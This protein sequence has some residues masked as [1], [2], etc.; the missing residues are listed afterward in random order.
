[1]LTNNVKVQRHFG[2]HDYHRKSVRYVLGNV[3]TS[4]KRRK[5]VR[6]LRSRQHCASVR[7]RQRF[8]LHLWFLISELNQPTTRLPSHWDVDP[9]AFYF[10]STDIERTFLS[11][12]SLFAGI[13]ESAS[14]TVIVDDVHMYLI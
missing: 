8:S 13:Y 11:A 2:R 4:C 10:R 5:T 3:A 7:H 9:D 1:M 6:R 14:Q 12:E